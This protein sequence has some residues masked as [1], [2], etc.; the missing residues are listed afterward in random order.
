[1]PQVQGLVLVIRPVVPET[2]VPLVQDSPSLVWPDGQPQVLALSMRVPEEQYFGLVEEHWLYGVPSE[3]VWIAGAQLSPDGVWPDGQPQILDLFI[4]WPPEQYLGFV[5]KHWLYCVPSEQVGAGAQVPDEQ[6]Q[7]QAA[8][9]D[10]KVLFAVVVYA[11]EPAEQ[12]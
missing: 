3:Q 6:P 1:M 4:S 8:W 12:V 11:Q 7:A 5:D 9:F 10:V 2:Q